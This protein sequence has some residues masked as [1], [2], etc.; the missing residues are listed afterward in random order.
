MNR[1]VELVDTLYSIAY[2][3]IV[4]SLLSIKPKLFMKWLG[5]VRFFV[6]NFIVSVVAKKG[7][8][9]DYRNIS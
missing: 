8:F 1:V 3:R 4:V 5:S 9:F 6:I 2:N 7:L